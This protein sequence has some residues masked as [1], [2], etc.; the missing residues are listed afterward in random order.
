MTTRS[1]ILNGFK[2]SALMTVALIV[3]SGQSCAPMP[4]PTDVVLGTLAFVD[5][6][7]DGFSDE[8][9]IGFVPGTDPFDPTDNPNNVRD[10]DGDG[11][12]DYDKTHFTYFCDGN[13][14][15]PPVDPLAVTDDLRIACSPLGL[16]DIEIR[17]LLT[18]ASNDKAN[19]VTYSAIL[20]DLFRAC[21]TFLSP[22][23]CTVCNT[24]IATQAYGF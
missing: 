16:T 23:N 13:P 12:S 19:G 22:W 24:A 15:T 5:S 10:T 1:S 6:D 20:S 14:F 2:Y 8:D 4:M 18:A 7:G 9:E 17:T 11:C 21:D 3:C